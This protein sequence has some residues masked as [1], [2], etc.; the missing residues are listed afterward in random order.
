MPMIIMYNIRWYTIPDQAHLPADQKRFVDLSE[1]LTWSSYVWTMIMMPV[2]FYLM[3]S[4]TYSMLNFKV[5]RDR[6][7]KKGY[8]NMY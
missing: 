4:I 6:I 7:K 5:A 1:D 3:W 8:D 2:L